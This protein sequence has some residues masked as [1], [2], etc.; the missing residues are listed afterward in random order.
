[1]KFDTNVVFMMNCFHKIKYH[2]NIL[3]VPCNNVSN[4]KSV[5]LNSNEITF[6][7]KNAKHNTREI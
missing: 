7:G 3:A 2:T 1:M 5:K 4:A 6:M